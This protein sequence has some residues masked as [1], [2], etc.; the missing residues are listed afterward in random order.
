GFSASD[1]VQRYHKAYAEKMGF[2]AAALQDASNRAQALFSRYKGVWAQVVGKLQGVKGYP[3][4][5]TFALGI[6][7]DQC[8]QAQN[9]QQQASSGD[10]SGGPSGS[11]DASS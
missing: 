3:V 1:E 11:S 7:G 8:K 10:S 5:S 9:A 2:D 6:G 4:R